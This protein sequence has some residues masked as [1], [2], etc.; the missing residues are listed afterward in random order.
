MPRDTHGDLYLEHVYHFPERPSPDNLVIVDCIEFNERFRYAD[1]VADV[2]FMIMDLMF[3]GREDLAECF[4]DFYFEAANDA[5]G[6]ALL[7][8][9][10]AYRAAVRAKVK[11]MLA[12]DATAPPAAREEARHK[13]RGHWLMSLSE[14]EPPERRPGLVLVGGLPGTGKTTLAHALARVA[15]FT[16]ISS[17]RVRKELAGLSPHSP[18]SAPF[19][20]GIYTPEWNDRT[21]AACI[22]QADRLLFDGERVI[23]DAS[24]REA[25]RRRAFL[26]A[27]LAHGVRSMFLVCTAPEQAVRVRL[28]ARQ[29]G[30]SDADWATHEAVARLWSPPRDIDRRWTAE[31][32]MGR[33]ERVGLRIALERLRTRGL[34]G[35]G[36]TDD[37]EPT[38]GRAG[39][40]DREPPT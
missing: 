18:A 23:V 22:E 20:E 4:A 28:E 19:G 6:R 5:E 3:S 15:R 12:H 39:H 21:Y 14:L 10:V 13:A 8:F 35:P 30:P 11:G 16:V 26:E 2:A 17:D 36:G 27:A 7:P 24:F 32:P 34:T 40:A 31:V 37:P 29:G 33:G 25:T 1:P 9:Y 38:R